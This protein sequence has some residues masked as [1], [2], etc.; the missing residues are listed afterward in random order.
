[1]ITLGQL[2]WFLVTHFWACN[3]LITSP[4][5]DHMYLFIVAQ[6]SSSH[7]VTRSWPRFRIS[8]DENS[9]CTLTTFVTWPL[10]TSASYAYQYSLL[11]ITQPDSLLSGILSE[12][13]ASRLPWHICKTVLLSQ[14]L[15][16]PLHALAISLI[17]SPLSQLVVGQLIITSFTPSF[18]ANSAASC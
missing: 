4:T 1:M 12:R 14:Q 6:I 9:T 15:I 3:E 2:L 8:P 7:F 11:Y 17:W 13:F 10:F 5:C 16:I 18:L